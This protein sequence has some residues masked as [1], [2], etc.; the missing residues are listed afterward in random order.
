VNQAK[1]YLEGSFPQ[2]MAGTDALASRWLVGQVFKLGPDF[3]SEFIPKI[4]ATRATQV[5]EAIKKDFFFGPK[6]NCD[7]R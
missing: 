1:A 6:V 2:Q 4:R 3:L 5:Q 7:C